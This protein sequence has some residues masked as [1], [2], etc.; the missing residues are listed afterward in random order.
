MPRRNSLTPTQNQVLRL[1]EEAGEETLG[2][3]LN[4][5]KA[6]PSLE[7][8]LTPSIAAVFDGLRDLGFIEWD[9]S[10]LCL[11]ED[12]ASYHFAE[13]S[14]RSGLLPSGK[15]MEIVLTAAGRRALAL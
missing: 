10:A 2:T 5:L 15:P 13:S 11:R 8:S 4:A 14:W 3:L 1:L 9:G 12:A 6:P 7:G